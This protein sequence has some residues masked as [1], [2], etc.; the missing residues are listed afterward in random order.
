MNVIILG[1]KFQK[2]MKS[3]GCVGLIKINNKTI[4][5]NQYKIIKNKFPKA[6]IVYVHGFESKKFYNFISKQNLIDNIIP[7]YNPE[8][9]KYNSTY[10]LK[11]AEQYLNTDCLILFGDQLLN[12][13]IFDNF[14]RSEKSKV[15][16]NKNSK[17]RLGCTINDNNIIENITYDLEN[18]LQ[19]IY[20]F[21]QNDIRLV[22]ELAINKLYYNY[23]IFELVNKLI[24]NKVEIIPFN[25]NNKKHKGTHN[26]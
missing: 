7:I 22:K 5:E 1:D 14:E 16:I 21:S 9:I 4:I 11:I 24:D 8:Y 23:F 25:V 2:R 19:E 6:N 13:N 18:Y 10:S 17:N 20:Y 26:V 15:F 12:T 3:K